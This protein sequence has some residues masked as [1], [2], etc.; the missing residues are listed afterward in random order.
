MVDKRDSKKSIVREFGLSTLAIN[1]RT[2]VI[3]LT[4]I[5]VFLGVNAY[6]TIPKEMAPE[7]KIPYVHV[8]TPYP[9]NS[10]V[11]IENLI[12][13]PIEKEIKPITGIKNITSTSVQDFSVILVEFNPEEDITKALQDVKDAVDKA[14]SEL[15]SDL[16][17]DPNVI[18]IDINEMPILYVNLYGNYTLNELKKYAEILEDEIEKLPEISKCEIKGALEREIRIDADIHKMDATMVNFGDIM[19]AIAAENITM[20]GGNIRGTDFQRSLRVVG[21]F[22]TVPEI[23]DIVVS[24]EN[25]KIVY[26]RDVAEVRDSYEERV[27]YSRSRSLPVVTVDVVKRAGEN[28]IIASD[29]IKGIVAEVTKERFPE[30]KSWCKCGTEGCNPK[31]LPGILTGSIFNN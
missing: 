30:L 10:P 1:N 3:I 16:D 9:G 8:S 18:D 20:S 24:D 22:S 28:L 31:D 4:L 7:V 2:S 27:S 15:P 25:G 19:N 12:T 26:L 21:E 11:D 17:T 13:R 14:K 29:K 5:I 6:L 23:E